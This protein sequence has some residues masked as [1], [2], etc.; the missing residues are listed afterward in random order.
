M[1]MMSGHVRVLML[2]IISND[3]DEDDD[4]DDADEL[5]TVL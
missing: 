4:D 1:V 3:D 2:P 5:E